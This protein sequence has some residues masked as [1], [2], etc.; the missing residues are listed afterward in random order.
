M[1]RVVLALFLGLVALL[2]LARAD[3][4]RQAVK[5]STWYRQYPPTPGNPLTISCPDQSVC[6]AAGTNGAVLHTTDGGQ[7]WQRQRTPLSKGFLIRAIACGSDRSCLASADDRTGSFRTV[8]LATTNGGQTWQKRHTTALGGTSGLA[9]PVTGDC[10]VLL[11]GHAF[12]TIS[13][14]TA[15]REQDLPLPTTA[16]TADGL[17]CPAPETC[18]V[19]AHENRG[20][21]YG[22]VLS[23]TDG[24][25]T[26]RT[27][28]ME[29]KRTHGSF[30]GIS[31]PDTK[32]CYV[33]TNRQSSG[34]LVTH[35]AWRTQAFDLINVPEPPAVA[36][37]DDY[38]A[39]P[40]CPDD[41]TCYV[42][43]TFGAVAA[44][45]DGAKTWHEHPL[46]HPPEPFAFSYFIP[47]SVV[48]MACPGTQRCLA[49]Q[50]N[51]NIARTTTGGSSWS[52]VFSGTARS[53]S[54]VACT[55]PTSCFAVGP[56]ATLL[57][58]TNGATWTRRPYPLGNAQGT[59]ISIACHGSS[60]CLAVGTNGAI[61]RTQNRGATWKRSTVSVSNKMQVVLTAAACPTAPTCYIG[62]MA[63]T[64]G[65]PGPVHPVLFRTVNAGATWKSL[66]LPPKAWPINAV[67]CASARICFAGGGD[68][69][70]DDSY[71][72][73]SLLLTRDG[74]TAW[75]TVGTEA[76]FGIT[77][78]GGGVCEVV[79]QSRG[80]APLAIRVTL[81]GKVVAR[82]QGSGQRFFRSSLNGVA[83]TAPNTCSAVGD[84]GLVA[85]TADGKGWTATALGLGQ[86]RA[87][88]CAG[89]GRCYAVGSDSTVLSTRAASPALTPVPTATPPNSVSVNPA[90]SPTLPPVV[91]TPTQVPARPGCPPSCIPGM[92]LYR[93]NW[94]LGFDGWTTGG[95]GAGAWQ[96]KHGVLISPAV[97]Y[98]QPA[99]PI[100][101]PFQPGA[102]GVANY[103]VQF[104]ARPVSQ[105]LGFH[106]SIR[107][108]G[109]RYDDF[110]VASC[111]TNNTSISIIYREEST[112][113]GYDTIIG[114]AELPPL[115]V[116]WH[117][118]RMEV[119][120]QK[121]RFIVD[122]RV[123]IRGLDRHVLKGGVVD[124]VGVDVPTMFRGFTLVA[125]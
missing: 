41:Q 10:F 79:G 84:D 103:A 16:M 113:G 117:T 9:C 4:G 121:L 99:S 107:R 58:T 7:S 39:Q 31:C 114:D 120:G 101:P 97:T 109:R 90:P 95:R 12:A 53:L 11:H 29:P 54:D 34:V 123:L 76:Y 48:G 32:T 23:T 15:W 118:F 73:G 69:S 43:S 82:W 71:P 18:F 105:G 110:S 80:R 2:G 106:V 119:Q 78:P 37:G 68:A 35:D 45:T 64:S 40:V 108:H 27:H 1:S 77:C 111:C 115:S 14:G 96:V 65:T 91:P 122:S 89:S 104:Q 44:T 87:A 60:L 59:L 52:T 19:D 42:R 75:R 8:V 51:G 38:F 116:R 66:P 102:H 93:A 22:A 124:L 74:G 20:D 46:D 100:R 55:D 67:A 81:S 6:Y 86:L 49:V 50:T 25:K 72:A 21:G 98:R 85:Y 24:G 28:I 47:L 83:C 70:D 57:A 63:Y 5:A 61:A 3:A 94:A 36:A 33:I 112:P 125:L 88:T 56:D 92:I 17:A 30:M 26:W 62:G 13:G